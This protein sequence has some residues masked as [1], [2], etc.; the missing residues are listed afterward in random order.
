MDLN[1]LANM[2]QQAGNLAN[3]PMAQ[4]IL[5]NDAI[6]GLVNQAEEM[7]NMDLNGNGSVGATPQ[8]QASDQADQ[9][10]ESSVTEE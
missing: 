8:A 7:T 5:N 3:N 6:S 2:A 4:Q 10:E 9:V 1:N